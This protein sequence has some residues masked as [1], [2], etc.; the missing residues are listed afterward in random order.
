MANQGFNE[1]AVLNELKQNDKQQLVLNGRVALKD[2]QRLFVVGQALTGDEHFGL[3]MGASPMPRTW[4][5]VSHLVMSAPN[6]LL[7]ITSLM[8]YSRLQLDFA[9]FDLCEPQGNDLVLSWQSN[10]PR[11]PSRHV[12]E[13]MFA[14]IVALANT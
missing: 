3:N 14:N 5:L 1:D 11:R 8:N 4:G 6:P 13:H 12:I 10:A 2:Y 7:A 9:Q